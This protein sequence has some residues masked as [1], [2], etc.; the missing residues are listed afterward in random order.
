MVRLHTAGIWMISGALVA[1][2]P[3]TY[4][5]P[6]L[7]QL[8]Q[9]EKQAQ[10]QLSQTKNAYNATQSNLQN[11]L[12]QLQ[13]LKSQW[14]S[15][16]VALGTTQQKIQAAQSAISSVQKLIART[17]AEMAAVKKSIDQTQKQYNATV[18]S[19]ARTQANLTK[20]LNML[21]GQLRLIEEHG[22]VG[23]VDVLVGSRTFSDFIS[24]LSLLGQVAAAAANEVQV[25]HQ[26]KAQ[27][28]QQ[29][30]QLTQQKIQLEKQ[31]SAV[32][33]HQAAL[34]KEHQLLASE[35]A[36]AQSLHQ[37]ALVDAQLTSQN[38]QKQKQLMNSLRQQQD[39]LRQQMSAISSEINRIAGQISSLLGQFNHGFLSRK[40]LYEAM[41]PLVTPIAQK[42]SLSPA[43]VIAVITEESGGNQKALS[44][45]GAIGL[46]QLEPG[47]AK[48]L[49]IDPYNPEQ[50]V[51]GGCLYL[52][53]M[54]NLF[55]GNLA[56]A[57][58]A[59]NAGPGAVEANHN[60]VPSYTQ[61]YVNNIEALYS[62][63]SKW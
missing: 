16:Q 62:L 44:Y 30:A 15:D 55:Q 20:E 37:A 32:S 12:A 19:I 25:I 43:L 17:E 34:S 2:G 27:E 7:Q 21:T 9:Q 59:Y 10:Q 1:V 52:H 42:F 33:A 51:L 29:K 56:L 13:H 23:Y 48:D 49:G 45:T 5:A 40:Q 36:Q 22:S 18:A 50:N 63:Y 41:L 54:L 26:E 14:S 31:K 60:Q 28:Q 24:R 35:E 57:L 61:D 46:M 8:Q 58:S 11:T 53:Q 4:A 39:A 6:N 38:M 47:T 3:M